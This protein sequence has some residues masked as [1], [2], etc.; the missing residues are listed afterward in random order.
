LQAATIAQMAEVLGNPEEAGSAATRIS[1]PFTLQIRNFLHYLQK[2]LVSMAWRFE[3][4]T[5]SYAFFLRSQKKWISLP[6]A[7]LLYGR[8]ISVFSQWLHLTHQVD[9]SGK[10][11]TRNLMANVWFVGREFMM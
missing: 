10:L 7:K 6:I 9:E 1:I 4:V 3:T 5:P 11:S 8:K 2:K